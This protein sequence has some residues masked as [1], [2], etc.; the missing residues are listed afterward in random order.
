MAS[1][2][3]LVISLF[4]FV[5][6]LP[7]LIILF[8][9]GGIEWGEGGATS[10][11]LFR[12]FIQSFLS[13]LFSVFLGYIGAIG[14]SAL[15][16][17]SRYIYFIALLPQGL[18]PL[19]LII[20]SMRFFSD[21]PFGLP[22]IVY[23]HTF[24]NIGLIAVWLDSDI[25]KK[26]SFMSKTAYLEG[27]SKLMF[28]W[29]T[30]PVLKNNLLMCFI[31]VFA[32]SLSSFSIPLMVGGMQSWSLE[33]GIYKAIF[34]YGNWKYAMGL[35]CIQIFILYFM[36]LFLRHK[37]NI[38]FLE[39]R[40]KMILHGVRTFVIFLF[41]AP[42]LILSGLWTNWNLGISQLR[43]AFNSFY[44]LLEMGMSSLFVGL[45]VGIG[46]W[47][48]FSVTLFYQNNKTLEKFLL[49]FISPSGAII[50]FS[51][52]IISYFYEMGFLALGLILAFFTTL[53]RLG[54]INRMDSVEN[55]IRV[56]ELLGASRLHIFKSIQWPQMAASIGFLSGLGALW[57]VGEFAVTGMYLRNNKTLSLL[58][59]QLAASY[60]L[61]AATIILLFIFIIGVGLF[62]TF[63]R[64][65][66]DLGQKS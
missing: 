30:L 15:K 50:G 10:T 31:F 49:G 33:I 62:F 26:L 35:S 43:N 13:A 14:L 66:Y 8:W 36:T 4:I 21:Y 22:A 46:L 40:D 64:I 2:N 11:L 41:I 39:E 52:I 55:Q 56:A 60:R 28:W 24:I 5:L 54:F 23:L 7:F 59:E 34:S 42:L 19:F 9:S 27:C 63:W 1:F 18:P 65:G 12:S 53:Y 61:E 57:S 20:G 45:A 51:L 48:F 44:P 25:R 58:A 38:F 16:I 47:I 29:K 37:K 17:S 6:V 32:L 3:K